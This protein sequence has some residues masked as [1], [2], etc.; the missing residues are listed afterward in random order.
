MYNEGSIRLALAAQHFP[1]LRVW[2]PVKAL[3]KILKIQKNDGVKSYEPDPL[4]FNT[5]AANAAV[6][7]MSLDKL[8]PSPVNYQ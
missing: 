3:A 5:R 1:K 6:K 4:Q 2:V 7:S 8:I